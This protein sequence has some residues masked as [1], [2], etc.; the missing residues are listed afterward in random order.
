MA[1]THG[2]VADLAGVTVRSQSPCN[3]QGA[4]ECRVTL[5]APFVLMLLPG[6]ASLRIRRLAT[7]NVRGF[8]LLNGCYRR[9]IRRA[10]I[11]PDLAGML[12]AADS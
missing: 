5:S 2:I 8:R 3:S 7:R 1:A 9:R 6:R 4:A 11:L 10:T 12:R